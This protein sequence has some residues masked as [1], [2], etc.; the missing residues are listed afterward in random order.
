MR[1]GQGKAAAF[2]FARVPPREVMILHKLGAMGAMST[3][4]CVRACVRAC[5][6]SSVGDAM[7]MCSNLEMHLGVYAIPGSVPTD[8]M[9]G[10]FASGVGFRGHVCVRACVPVC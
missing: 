8:F 4:A 10:S 5:V 1:A 2:L 3:C 7:A 6:L 9:S